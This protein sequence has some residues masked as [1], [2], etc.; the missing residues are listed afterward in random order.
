MKMYPLAHRKRLAGGDGGAVE[1]LGGTL[2]I[3]GHG[4]LQRSMIQLYGAWAEL[5]MVT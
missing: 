3:F 1:Q 2:A 4:A 5:T